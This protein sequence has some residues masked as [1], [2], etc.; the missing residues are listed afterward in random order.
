MLGR[1]PRDESP[2]HPLQWQ[3]ALRL[4]PFMVGVCV[5]VPAEPAVGFMSASSILVNKMVMNKWDFD[6][7]L[8]MVVCQMFVSLFLLTILKVRSKPCVQ[9]INNC[10]SFKHF[11]I[12]SFPDWNYETAIK[13]APLAFSHLANTLSGLYALNLV[14]VPMFGYGTTRRAACT[15]TTTENNA[16]HCGGW[17][18]CL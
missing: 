3:G 15:D 16:A 7:P 17:S 13:A 11:S 1:A 2:P 4:Q 5:E 8:I 6:F 12:I 9:R 14:D 18:P 10:F